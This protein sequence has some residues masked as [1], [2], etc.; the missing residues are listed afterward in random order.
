[1]LLEVLSLLTSLMIRKEHGSY[2][3]RVNLSIAPD[4]SRSVGNISGYLPQRVPAP[5]CRHSLAIL[6]YACG[7]LPVVV[8]SIMAPGYCV[9]L[10]RE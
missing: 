6:V 7:Y 2:S 10:K 3:P 5:T 9:F 4:G 1:M 8:V